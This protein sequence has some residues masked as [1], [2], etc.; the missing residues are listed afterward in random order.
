MTQPWQRRALTYYDMIG[1]LRFASHFYARQM[2]KVA[3]F[4]A[5][6][7]DDG[8]KEPITSGLPVDLLKRIQDPGGGRAQLQFNFG[9][10][11]FITGEGVLFGSGIDTDAEMWRFLWKEEVRRQD[12]GSYVRL[13]FDMKPTGEVGVAYRIW[14]SHPRHSDEP[15]SPLRGVLDLA[16]ELIALTA[17]VRSTAVTR[18][19]NGVMV[20]PLEAIPS[21]PDPSSDEDAETNPFL[22]D[23]IEH[24]TNEIEKPGAAEARVPFLYTPP[25][26]YAD[27]FQ[28]VA[29]HD[30]ATDYME[31]DLRTECV[32]RMALGLDMPPEALLGM[33]EAN[34]WTGRQVQQDVWRSHGMLKAEQFASDVAQAYLRPALEAEGYADWR[35]VV[36]DYDD[37][38]V[39]ISPDR[40]TDANDALDR[41]AIGFEGYR[42][43]KSIPED[44]KPTQE[45]TDFLAALKIR[46]PTLLAQSEGITPPLT[47]PLRGPAP[48]PAQAPNPS[49]G[50]P[51]PSNGRSGSRQESMRAS[52]E[53]LGGAKVALWRCRE[54]AGARLRR[55]QQ[56]CLDCQ[57]KTDGKPNALV[58]SILGPEQVLELGIKEPVKLVSGGT[59]G[60]IHLLRENGYE[61]G[62]AAAMAQT[63]EIYAAKTLF[64]IN[65]SLPS[66]FESLV[67][68]AEEVKDALAN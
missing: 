14:Y 2:A 12:D 63:L 1:E 15:D 9:R 44:F 23:Y 64:E 21:N 47:T 60:F 50:P 62:Q 39:V 8:T 10:L 58:A 65:P 46:D 42:K 61:P 37:S 48:A 56:A 52:A 13:D 30:P 54:V 68:K 5:T 40:T 53:I 35:E 31:K 29:T 26:E 19:T 34:H 28:W 20:M 45:E 18:L 24:V 27:R 33:T 67:I 25:Y 22:A 4:P 57:T 11:M 55:Y 16:E 36:I 32:N 59:D 7:R 66:G 17:A 43:L 3:F 51:L 49:D 41:I 6:L 38:G